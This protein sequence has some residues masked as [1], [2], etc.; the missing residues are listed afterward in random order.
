[1]LFL[2][3]NFVISEFYQQAQL[4]QSNHATHYV[5]WNLVHCCAALRTRARIT[6]STGAVHTSAKA[7]LTGVAIRIRLR[8]RDPDRHQNLIICSMVHCQPS[9]K[10]SCKSVQ[11]FLGKVANRQTNRQT[12]SDDY[13]SSLVEVTSINSSLVY[14]HQGAHKLRNFIIFIRVEKQFQSL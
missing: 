8:I 12:N 14:V 1:M 5:V 11:K 3:L 13:I 9:L 6:R 7:R 4:S 10:I 2:F